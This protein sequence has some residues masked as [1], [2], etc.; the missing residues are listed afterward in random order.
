M[1]TS[2]SSKK[3][4]ISK[5]KSISTL[6]QIFQKS[7]TR[8]VLIKHGFPGPVAMNHRKSQP[9]LTPMIPDLQMKK[10][11]TSVGSRVRVTS[12]ER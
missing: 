6:P 11:A 7:Q 8:S 1:K 10:E 12:D 3:N 5:S 2:R 4:I 9:C